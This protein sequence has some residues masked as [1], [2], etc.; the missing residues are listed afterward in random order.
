MKWFAVYV[1]DEHYADVRAVSRQAAMW[2]AVPK[3][4]KIKGRSVSAYEHSMD[5]SAE[6]EMRRSKNAKV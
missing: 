6:L 5:E 4:Y 2:I 3:L 1:G